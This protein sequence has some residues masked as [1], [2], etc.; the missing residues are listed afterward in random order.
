MQ[1]LPFFDSILILLAGRIL[2]G[3]EVKGSLLLLLLITAVFILC[4]LNLGLIIST[5]TKSQQ[6]TMAVAFISSVVPSFVLSD[7]VFP[8][9]NMPFV[10]QL[11]SYFIPA[12]YYLEVIRGVIL[13]GNGIWE[14][15]SS[16]SI[17]FVFMVWTFGV[18]TM[19]LKKLMREI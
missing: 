1:F 17:L 11:I 14:H 16:I 4:G 18:G 3:L 9:R 7:F 2:F 5:I 19:R 15:I 13:K 8:I 12:R 6:A 10:L